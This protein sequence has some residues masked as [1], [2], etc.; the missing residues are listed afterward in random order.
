[1][2]STSRQSEMVRGSSIM[3]LIS[4]R[5]VL[6]SASLIS[7]SRRDTSAA[8]AGSSRSSACTARLTWACAPRAM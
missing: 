3:K 8:P 5:S 7:A 6:R 4:W 2:N 1:M